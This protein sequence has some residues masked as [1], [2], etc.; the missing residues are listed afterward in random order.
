[1]DEVV[2]SHD[3]FHAIRTEYDRERGVLIYFWTCEG[4]GARLREVGRE[5]YRPLFDPHG[6]ERFFPSPGLR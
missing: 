5:E 3:G 6:H 1:L 4:C 2:C